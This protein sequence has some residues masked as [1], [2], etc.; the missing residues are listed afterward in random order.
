MR[1]WA[2]FCVCGQIVTVAMGGFKDLVTL[3]FAV[4]NCRIGIFTKVNQLIEIFCIFASST[5]NN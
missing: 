3:I 4:Q 2:F 5:K 1:L